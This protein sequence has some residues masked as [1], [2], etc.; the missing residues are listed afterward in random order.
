[1]TRMRYTSRWLT[2]R[3]LAG[4][5]I[6]VLAASA[7]ACTS[8]WARPSTAADPGANPTGSASTPTPPRGPGEVPEPGG[9]VTMQRTGG[10]AGIMQSIEI[11]TDGTW[12]Y[13]DHKAGASKRGRLSDAERQRLDR[14]LAA[15]TLASEAN[16]PGTGVCNDG[17]RYAITAGRVRLRFEW[18]GSVGNRPALV[19]VIKAIE[20]ATPM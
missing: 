14:T 11:S 6:G 7:A 10:L 8:P 2:T 19:A 16:G 18:C 17:L 4:V 3:G 9:A 15:P 1:M 20:D 12:L 5:V 13:T